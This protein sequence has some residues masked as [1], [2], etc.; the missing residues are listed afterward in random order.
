MISAARMLTCRSGATAVEFALIAFPLLMLVLG[1]LQFV[2]YCYLQQTISDALYQTA[3]EPEPEILA[4]DKPGYVA[5]ICAKV[6]FRQSCL[7]QAGGITVEAMRLPN[8][9]T[10]SL[11]ITGTVFDTGAS[12]DVILLR[13][14]MPA[15]RLV[16]MVP[17][18]VAQDSVVFRR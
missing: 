8:V 5:R 14:K 17:E 12:Q 10:A 9:P 6:A 18:L 11:A 7:G 2:V 1:L 16:P 13:A 4:Q 15:P 3:S